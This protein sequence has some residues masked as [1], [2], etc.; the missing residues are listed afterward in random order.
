MEEDESLG[1]WR[2]QQS[3]TFLSTSS[4]ASFSV[5]LSLTVLHTAGHVVN[6][7]IF[8]VTPLSVLSCLFPSVFTNDG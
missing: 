8:S 6:V 2:H 1:P 3:D 5:F 4:D 7:Y